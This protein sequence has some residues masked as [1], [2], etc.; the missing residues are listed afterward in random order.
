MHSS[1]KNDSMVYEHAAHHSNNLE[2]KTHRAIDTRR[3]RPTRRIQVAPADMIERGE[4]TGGAIKV[5]RIDGL[6][7]VRRAVEGARKG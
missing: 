4:S 1:E 3:T 6:C 2:L 5:E 7:P